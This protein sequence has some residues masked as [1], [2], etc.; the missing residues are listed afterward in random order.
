MFLSLEEWQALKLSLIV[1]TSTTVVSLPFGIFLG[2]ILA[3]KEFAGKFIVEILINLSLVLPPVVVGYMLLLLLGTKG[4]LGSF[5]NEQFGI[6]IAF[7]IWAAIL[8]AAVI[9]FP[10]LV[11][12]VRLAFQSVDERYE[13]AARTLGASKLNTFFTISLPL[14]KNGIIAGAII[15]FARSLGEFGATVVFAGNIAN[16][17]QTLALAIFSFAERP[18][19]IEAAWKLVLLSV[20]VSA[21]ALIWS[22]SLERKNSYE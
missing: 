19:G 4:Y 21:I 8:A 2:Y 11:R 10:L 20:M 1:A 5:F 22:Q 18:G 16:Q 12:S 13:L 6:S 14:A 7:T 15:T 3:R 17:T 9:S